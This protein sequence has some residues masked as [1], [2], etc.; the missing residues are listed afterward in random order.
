M[1]EGGSDP[2]RSAFA[3][4]IEGEARLLLL[5]DGFSSSTSTLQGRTKLAKLDFLL[6]YPA[7]FRRA[8]RIRNISADLPDAADEEHT[9]EERMVR[10]RYGPWDPAY[11]ALLGSLLGR[12]LIEAIP[13]PRYIGFRATEKGHALAKQLGATEAWTSLAARVRL[14]KRAFPTQG[15]T[16]LKDFIYEHFPEVSQATWGEGL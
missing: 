5:I 14:L 3:P 4:S 12:G 6:R 1:P 9:V 15:G 2:R 10:F 11:Y 7:F 8:M 13:H 16:F